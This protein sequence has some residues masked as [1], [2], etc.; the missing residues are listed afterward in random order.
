M[1]DVICGLPVVDEGSALSLLHTDISLPSNVGS[2]KGP[3][4]AELKSEQSYVEPPKHLGEKYAGPMKFRNLQPLVKWMVEGFWYLN[5]I[6][7]E[8]SL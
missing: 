5:I 8:K 3:S 7:D 4:L 1:G 6:W 2:K